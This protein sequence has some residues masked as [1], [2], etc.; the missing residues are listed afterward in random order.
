VTC[1][2]LDA[3]VQAGRSK[4]CGLGK[5]DEGSKRAE[6]RDQSG[7]KVDHVGGWHVRLRG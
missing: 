4:S 2:D 1:D 3:C 6:V 7:K 5:R